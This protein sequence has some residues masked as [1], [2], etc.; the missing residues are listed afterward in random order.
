MKRGPQFWPN[1]PGLCVCVTGSASSLPRRSLNT[2]L[3]SETMTGDLSSGTYLL[4]TQRCQTWM[5]FPWCE[6]EAWGLGLEWGGDTAEPWFSGSCSRK[7]YS[8]ERA[9]PGT[10][11]LGLRVTE[12]LRPATSQEAF[13]S[14]V[15]YGREGTTGPALSA[16]RGRREDRSFCGLRLRAHCVQAQ[17]WAPGTIATQDTGSRCSQRSRSGGKDASKEY[18]EVKR[19]RYGVP[20][21]IA[22]T[23]RE[24]VQMW[25]SLEEHTPISFE[26]G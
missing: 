18:P 23:Y 8:R 4:L 14:L 1:P 9:L 17:R 26:V 13:L 12:W 10:E 11:E 24:T 6:M 5:P 7:M 15:P 20:Q 21:R 3:A 19:E 25:G 2:V 16:S 22:L